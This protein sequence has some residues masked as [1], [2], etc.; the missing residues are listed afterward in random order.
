MYFQKYNSNEQCHQ[1]LSYVFLKTACTNHFEWFLH[2]RLLWVPVVMLYRHQKLKCSLLY[3]SY[4]YLRLPLLEK[5]SVLVDFH[6]LF[7]HLLHSCNNQDCN[8]A[9]WLS[10]ISD[11]FLNDHDHL[12]SKYKNHITLYWEMLYVADHQGRCNNHPLFAKHFRCL[13]VFTFLSLKLS[14]EKIKI[15]LFCV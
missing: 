7:P 2:S 1:N 8:I 12:Y 4:H 11:H 3:N 10:S 14:K 6:R 9:L 13:F 5:R 15:G